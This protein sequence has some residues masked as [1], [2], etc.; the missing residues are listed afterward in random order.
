M[1]K[2]DSSWN[3]GY[4]QGSRDVQTG[5]TQGTSN[6]NSNLNNAMNWQ[7]G[8]HHGSRDASVSQGNS[9]QGNNSGGNNRK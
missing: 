9:G 7:D 5:N 4:Q 2:N 6:P 3:K 1:S 8:Y